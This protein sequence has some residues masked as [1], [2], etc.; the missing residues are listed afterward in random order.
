[1]YHN[2]EEV[3]ELRHLTAYFVRK[4]GFVFATPHGI[5]YWAMGNDPQRLS[6]DGD[7]FALEEKDDGIYAY[8][9]VDRVQT[10]FEEHRDTCGYMFEEWHNVYHITVRE[11]RLPL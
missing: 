6:E 2:D 3:E 10:A 8:H 9:Y 11:E 4:E 7:C 1:M 5:F